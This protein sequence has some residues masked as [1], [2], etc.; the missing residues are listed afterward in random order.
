M[1]SSLRADIQTVMSRDPAASSW[2]EVLLCYPGLRAVRRHRLANWLYRHNHKVLARLRAEHTRRLTGIDIHPGAT[3]GKGLFIDHGT[4]VVIGET[5]IVG[6]NCTLYQNC[7]LG[8]TGKE[9]GKRHPTIG[10][11]VMISAGA[12]VLGN[13]TIGDNCKVG[14]GAVVLMDVPANCT[15]VGVPGRVV[16]RGNI[17]TADLD[18]RLPDPMLEEFQR[19]C[20]RLLELERHAE[21]KKD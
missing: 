4:G 6:E 17:R 12:K 15:V 19:M 5:T 1:F 9:A 18:Q 7:T 20:A 14:A 10:N 11:N 21:K 16:R 8:G 13:I 3:L 2:L